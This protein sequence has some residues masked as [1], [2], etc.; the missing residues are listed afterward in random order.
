MNL[1]FSYRAFRVWQRNRDVFLH[2]WKTEMSLA[3]GEPF[4]ILLA[5][6]YGLG[7]YVALSQGQ[8]YLQFIAPGIVASYAMYTA[9]SECT[10]GSYVRMELQ[11]TFDAIIAT[12]VNIEDVIAGEIFWAAT[13]SA[14]TGAIILIVAVLFGLVHSLWALLILPLMA[15]AGLMFGAVSMLFTAVV[16]S[17]N[18]FNYY[19]SLFVTPMFF[20]GGVFF[21]LSRLPEVVQRLAWFVPLTPVVNLSRAMVD[22]DLHQ[23]L[24]I[25]L[26]Y[27]VVV[28]ALFF[29]ASIYSMKKRLII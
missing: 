4:L 21:P 3:F 18:S 22:G 25:D 6:G 20:F 19:F 2:L 10:Y 29:A 14:L 27:V 7:S 9:T 26:L 15:L 16:P 17:I 11:K 1:P 28:A 23:G 8:S 5:M 13:R 24:F 12:P